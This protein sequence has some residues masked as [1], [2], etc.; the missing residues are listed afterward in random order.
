[1]PTRKRIPVID[2]FAGP[3]GLGEGFARFP[4]TSKNSPRFQ[5]R[6][7]I[8]K[9]P[10]AHQTLQL[11]SFRLQFKERKVP[12]AYYELLREVDRPLNKR[13]LELFDAYPKEFRTASSETICAELGNPDYK[14]VIESSLTEAGLN[15]TD[16]TL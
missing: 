14:K 4:Y 15:V 11:R 2:I 7:S 6:A 9:D 12:E 13:L 16:L 3:G 5:I 8:E 1:M 10:R